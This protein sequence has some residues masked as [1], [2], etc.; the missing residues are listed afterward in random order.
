MFVYSASKCADLFIQ[1]NINQSTYC[2]LGLTIVGLGVAYIGITDN[3]HAVNPVGTVH[4]S[5]CNYKHK[6]QLMKT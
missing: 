3:L 4:Y 6:N 5:I 2:S 1:V